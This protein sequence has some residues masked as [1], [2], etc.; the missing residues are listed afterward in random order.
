MR[1]VLMRDARMR[2]ARMRDALRFLAAAFLFV[3]P[4]LA[5]GP[6]RAGL[7]NAE[8]TVLENGL[9]VVVVPSGRA[10]IVTQMVYYKAGSADERPGQAGIAH[11]LEHLMFKGSDHV[12]DHEFDRFVQRVGGRANAFTTYDITAY[13]Q[14]V[15]AEKLADIMRF[16]ADRMAHP[17]LDQALATPELEVVMQERRQR[18]DSQPGGTLF[19][20]AA[21]AFYPNHPYGLPTIGWEPDIRALTAATARTFH[22]TWYVPNN[23]VLVISGKTSMAEVLPLARQFYGPIPQRPVPARIRPIDPPR[24]G[25]V[26]IQGSSERKTD[27]SWTRRFPAPSYRQDPARSLALEILSEILGGE[28]GRLTRALTIDS[29]AAT[30][31]GAYYSPD[32]LDGTS[33]TLAASVPTAQPLDQMEKL[34]SGEI[35]RLLKDG[36]TDAELD[37]AKSRIVAGAA[38]AL[39]GSRGAAEQIGGALAI[40]MPL[41]QIESW[42]ERVRAVPRQAIEEAARVV[43][44][45]KVAV[46]TVLRPS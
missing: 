42:P 44:D 3:P 1:D 35:A 31:V 19:E 45:D 26:L 29:S 22:D 10:P 6:A 7:Y 14:T 38:Y 17:T 37:S 24:A 36:L 20:Q 15:P 27:I 43:F 33:F 41:E 5:A 8:H 23:A 30:Y 21:R 32:R 4:L 12:A 16:E 2:D 13:W 18:I 39:D 40:G 25:A 46:T 34:L 11:F 9:E 28:T